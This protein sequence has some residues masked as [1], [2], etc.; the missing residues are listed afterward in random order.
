MR[1]LNRCLSLMSSVLLIEILFLSGCATTQVGAF[2]KAPRMESRHTALSVERLSKLDSKALSQHHDQL[3]DARTSA[4]SQA[5][6]ALGIRLNS[7]AIVKLKDV[8]A[9]LTSEVSLL[10]EAQ[11][12]E[13]E[14]KAIG[15]I[16][17]DIDIV[18]ME[19]TRIRKLLSLLS[20]NR[21]G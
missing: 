7:V 8:E 9:I 14:F 12:R 10:Q 19:R 4:E 20:V 17:Q 3:I 18:L 16:G 1:P 2:E 13:T 6:R 15:K 11:R 21:D 5:Q